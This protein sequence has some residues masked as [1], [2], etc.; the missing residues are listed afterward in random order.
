MTTEPTASLS[1]VL[2]DASTFDHWSSPPG[3]VVT[4]AAL[5]HSPHDPFLAW[6][7]GASAATIE[8]L[9]AYQW[10]ASA[11]EPPRHT[12]VW[13]FPQASSTAERAARAGAIE[14]LRGITQSVT[15]EM[16]ASKALVN[17]IA[18]EASDL[19]S[20]KAV[21]SF[22]SSPGGGFTAGSTFDLTSKELR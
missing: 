9:R 1:V 18:C 13:C 2:G 15:R 5:E 6:V 12:L 14:S 17:A 11:D 7:V 10:T 4:I 20:A 21:I 19:P 16:A 22:L 8:K 3:M